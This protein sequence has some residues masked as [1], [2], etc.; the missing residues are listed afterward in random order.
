MEKILV[1]NGNQPV[2]NTDTA[3]VGKDSPNYGV[4]YGLNRD[5][6]PD[7]D[8]T[9]LRMSKLDGAK[10]VDMTPELKQ[11]LIEDL[12]YAYGNNTKEF[13][14]RMIHFKLY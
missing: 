6:Q 8:W 13:T 11:I 9:E 2:L 5:R 4:V 1:F 12:A 10:E 7:R 14:E 3:K